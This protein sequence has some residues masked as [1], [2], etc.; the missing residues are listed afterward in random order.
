[1]N[2]YITTIIAIDPLDGQLAEFA[3]PYVPGHSFEDAQRYCNAN[4]MGYCK[5]EGQLCEVINME[6]NSPDINILT[7]LN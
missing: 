2:L 1:M 5:V 7:S 3:G 4:G 6:N